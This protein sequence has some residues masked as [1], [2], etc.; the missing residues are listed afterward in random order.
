VSGL[1]RS[2]ISSQGR[3][4]TS[5]SLMPMVSNL[6]AGPSARVLRKGDERQGLARVAAP[7]G[8][9][10]VGQG[11]VGRAGEEEAQLVGH[12]GRGYRERPGASISADGLSGAPPVHACRA[13]RAHR[14]PRRIARS[15]EFGHPVPP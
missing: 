6:G 15:H 4:R 2:A 9:E 1:A 13:C 14:G 10:A 8:R 12:E 5:R 7:R 3:R 11:S